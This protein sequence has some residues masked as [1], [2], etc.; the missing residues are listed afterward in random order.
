MSPSFKPR[1][2]SQWNF[3]RHFIG[4]SSGPGNSPR[5]QVRVCILSCRLLGCLNCV[6]GTC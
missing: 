2:A 4:V 1:T 6:S 3:G 5:L